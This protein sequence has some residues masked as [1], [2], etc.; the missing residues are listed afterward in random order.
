FT[1]EL[2]YA[3]L[4][5][6]SDFAVHSAKDLPSVT[7]D[8]LPWLAFGQRESTRDILVIAPDI[9]VDDLENINDLKIGTSSPRRRAQLERIFPLANIVELRGNVPTRA[10]KVLTGEMHAVVLAEAGLS[11]L[12]LLE[13]LSQK[14]VQFLELPFVTAP[15]QGILGLQTRK[16]NLEILMKL[17]NLELSEI[18]RLEKSVLM[19]LGGGCHLEVGCEVQKSKNWSVDF[20]WRSESQEEID[21]SFEGKNPGTLLRDL[22]THIGTSISTSATAGKSS[23]VNQ[24]VWI[25]SPLRSQLKPHVSLAAAG[26][27]PRAW[28]LIEP[29]PTWN[30]QAIENLK[31]AWPKTTCLV[32]TSPFGADVFLKEFLISL[33]GIAALKEKKIFCVGQVTQAP[34]L[35]LGIETEPLPMKATASALVPLL[36]SQSGI[37]IAGT[38]ESKLLTEL[39][40][41]NV[42]CDFL[43]LYRSFDSGGPLAQ[44][45]D[46]L[47]AQ[48]AVVFTSASA[49]ERFSKIMSPKEASGRELYAIGPSTAA[50][51][52]TLGY[53]VIVSPR[54]GSW[55]ALVSTIKNQTTRGIT[56]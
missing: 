22:F 48:D 19:F 7:H 32:I 21:F 35:A 38:P 15:C 56:K 12:G 10:N 13:P 30:L 1:K 2:E 50:K 39:K 31:K 17:A 36:K 27:V 4:G 16:E 52:E 51:L 41:E 29:K 44:R 40:A 43:E 20:Y 42:S 23:S 11:R 25:T 46:D 14:G 8:E 47:G 37:L 24:K 9:D 34:F 26:L 53:K 33:G 3:L 45:P 55:N 6:T 49:A 18:A 28:P 54:S 5:G